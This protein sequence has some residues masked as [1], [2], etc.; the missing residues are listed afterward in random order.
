MHRKF[1]MKLTKILSIVMVAVLCLSVAPTNL[2]AESNYPHTADANKINS[3][4]GENDYQKQV[5]R[6]L[7]DKETK[8]AGQCH[9]C[10]ITNLLNRKLA[11]DGKYTKATN[12]FD[13]EYV[14]R[15]NCLACDNNTIDTVQEALDMTCY[16]EGGKLI[17]EHDTDGYSNS[18]IFSVGNTNY[19]FICTTVE[20]S[21]T[22]QQIAR[23]L[24]AH[25]EG[26]FVR[27]N[28][29][30]SSGHCVVVTNYDIVDG[31]YIFKVVDTGYSG[32]DEQSLEDSYLGTK[33]KVN[34]ETDV[35]ICKYVNLAN[36][37]CNNKG[38]NKIAKI[39]Y[40]VSTS[41]PAKFVKD[42]NYTTD[43]NTNDDNTTGNEPYVTFSIPE[44]GVPTNL[45]LNTA[46]DLKG[47]IHSNKEITEATVTVT[48][49]GE[50]NPEKTV[51]F[52]PNNDYVDI[53]S[54]SLNKLSFGKL[55]AGNYTLKYT[56][57]AGDIT[58]ESEKYSFTVGNSTETP[59]VNKS[60][61]TFSIT[62]TGVPTEHLFGTKF[63]LTGTIRSTQS[64]ITK[65]TVEVTKKGEVTP[66]DTTTIYPGSKS[67]NI[68]KTALNYDIS[69]GTLPTGDYILKYTAIVD[70]KPFYSDEYNFT[71]K[72]PPKVTFS[73]TRVPTRI[74][75]GASY[76]L[77]GTIS[78]NWDITEATVKIM[79]PGVKDP[80]AKVS[81]TPD[82]N[83]V[84]IGASALNSDLRFGDIPTG[85][86]ILVYSAIAG[87]K[88]F[89]TQSSF[90]VK[91]TT[92]TPP[93]S[94][95]IT[96]VPSRLTK[97]SSF[98]LAGTISSNQ[99]ITNATVRVINIKNG[100]TTTKSFTPNSKVV[101]IKSS[102]LNKLS[103][104]KLPTGNYVL[105]YSVTAGGKIF[106]S[107]TYSF[108]VK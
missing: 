16:I 96:S 93:V 9:L 108:T 107:S 49:E 17:C 8:I 104:G 11:L 61:V 2:H 23:L 106:N 58:F 12:R 5:T 24:D 71:V 76:S 95:S 97:G 25:H 34:G 67:V 26:V 70:D 55:K 91:S 3:I 68:E 87:G 57:I 60:D 47:T 86:Y 7:K 30:T 75:K 81:I 45:P 35:E 40:L 77:A 63:K 15:I 43:N 105:I 22:E 31:K 69:F 80:I 13:I 50:T 19:Q 83:Y 72:E 88:S 36:D 59:A 53:I 52:S 103:F 39:G 99:T 37:Y 44:T 66:R 21:N 1:K 98:N 85:D 73:L 4:L 14:A 74:T 6:Y 56:A 48:R 78:S 65:A 38:Y 27:V 29:P 102:Y 42:G 20:Y 92:V 82:S 89:G 64:E 79:K 10:A 32:K 51:S 18:P 54:S 46:F 90:S 100:A 101:N 94:F 84:N 28:Y 62:E 33:L 41:T